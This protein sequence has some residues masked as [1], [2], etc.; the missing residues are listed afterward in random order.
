MA[1]QSAIRTFD[2]PTCGGTAT[3][4]V[5]G[6][7]DGRRILW[8][9]S[10]TC[11]MC[12]NHELH[13][14]AVLVG[15]DDYVLLRDQGGWFGLQ[16][17]VPGADRVRLLRELRGALKLSLDEVSRLLAVRTGPQLCGLEI[18]MRHVESLVRSALP[19]AET[20]VERITDFSACAQAVT[21]RLWQSD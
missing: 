17:T 9:S 21:S 20:S 18:E 4:E 7:L 19:H 8:D 14:R 6:Y 2:C 1:H 12:S 15:V 5:T 11:A 13:C 3:Y 16:V 10:V